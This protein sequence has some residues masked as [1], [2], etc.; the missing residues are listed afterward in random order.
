VHDP[1]NDQPDSPTEDPR[2]L[3]ERLEQDPN[4]QQLRRS[5]LLERLLGK[6]PTPAAAVPSPDE[7]D[8]AGVWLDIDRAAHGVWITAKTADGVI[9]H[10]GW[11]ARSEWSITEIQQIVERLKLRLARRERQHIRLA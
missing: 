5:L 6:G 2:S 9:A 11:Y 10:R 3:L 8:G 4:V 7:H 1:R